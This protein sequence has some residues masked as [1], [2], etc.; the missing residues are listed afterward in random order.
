MSETEAAMD[1]RLEKVEKRALF[2]VESLVCESSDSSSL[3]SNLIVISVLW[4][5]WCFESLHQSAT[6]SS[7]GNQVV[8]SLVSL[9]DSAL[10]AT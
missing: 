6:S 8:D 2:L 9:L 3:S 5:F 10:Q 4:V 1:L 7:A